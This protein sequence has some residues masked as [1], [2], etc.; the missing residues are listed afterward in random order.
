MPRVIHFEFPAKN[1]A[2]LAAFYREVFGWEFNQWE[3][4]EYWLVKTGED[5]APGINGGMYAPR[6][7]MSGTVNTI[8]VPDLG[9]VKANGGQVVEG[10]MPVPTVGWLAYCKDAE[11]NLFGMMQA[12]PNASIPE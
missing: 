9:K 8:D 5:S 11:G 4:V 1:S 2:R 7:G 3:G 10:K 12:D 6:D